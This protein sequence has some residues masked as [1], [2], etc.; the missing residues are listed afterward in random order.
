MT[1]SNKP[2]PTGIYRSGNDLVFRLC[3]QDGKRK[4]FKHRFQPC[5]FLPAPPDTPVEVAEHFALR[6]E[7]DPRNKTPLVKR[8]F[9]NMYEM[10]QYLDENFDVPGVRLY[11]SKSPV[12]QAYSDFFPEDIKPNFK[13]IRCMNLDIEVVSSFEKD[14]MIGF[15]PFPEPIIEEEQYRSNSFNIDI[16]SDHVTEFYKWWNVEFPNSVIPIWTNMNAAFP[17]VSL[18]LSDKNLNKQII[19]GLPLRRNRNKFVYNPKDEEISGLDVEYRE[20]STEQDM[21]KDF[22]KY[23]ASRD[24]DLWTGWNISQF[25]A[26]YLAERVIKILGSDWV[27]SLSTIG[28]AYKKLEK[29]KKGLPYNTWVFDGVPAMP[30]DDLYRRH[31]LVER[32]RY[33]LDFISHI[34][35]DEQKLSYAHVKSLN[36]LWFVEYE[37]FIRYGIKDINLVDKLDAK[38]G[39]LNLTY[40]LAALYKCNYSET[41][42]TVTPW[43]SL[44]YS[45]NAKK[46]RYPLLKRHQT[47]TDSFPGAFVHDPLPGRYLWLLSE[48]LN[49]LYPHIF[50]QYNLGPETIVTESERRDIIYEMIQEVDAFKRIV[51]RLRCWMLYETNVKSSTNW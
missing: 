39:Y 18:Q 3:T 28:R 16:Y 40:M 34:E 23:W 36:T 17:I 20:F 2:F 32:A 42:S 12:I 41:L 13:H 26:P 1:E 9:D 27:N 29:P 19:W 6:G 38:L 30:Y 31:R 51:Q 10:K 35:L 44:L 33:S 15:G 24:P 8:Q 14:G 11:G 46:N 45:F 7:P 25:D 5:L 43:S 21:L 49:S 4:K 22:I 50:Q 47:F 37:N 48:D